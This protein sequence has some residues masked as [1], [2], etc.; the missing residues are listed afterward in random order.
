V[1][2]GRARSARTPAGFVT[3]SGQALLNGVVMVTYCNWLRTQ[4][5]HLTNLHRYMNLDF[6]S[7]D[8]L[9]AVVDF[10]CWFVR[11]A[12]DPN[13]NFGPDDVLRAGAGWR[14]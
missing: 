1:R 6:D 10:L 13:Q 11:V 2:R 8:V 4:S 12:W 7:D 9:T 14:S 3:L 5:M